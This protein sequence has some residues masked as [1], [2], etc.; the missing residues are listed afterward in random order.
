MNIRPNIR[1]A[2]LVAALAAVT[3]TAW[4][5]T[6][7]TDASWMPAG[8][9]AAERPIA[10]MPVSDS[11]SQNE[12][13]VS[14]SSDSGVSPLNDDARIVPVPF[15]AQQSSSIIVE[16]RRPSEDERIQM[17]VI[18]KL[19]ASPNLSGKIGV[20]TNGSVVTLTG[21]TTTAG[22]AWRAGR[23]AGSVA[24]VK[25]VQNEI[26]ARIGGSV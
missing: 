14:P 19:A 18:D 17:T 16:E 10:L 22:Q 24:G 20:V 4:A 11:L 12:T 21:Y 23:A 13:I 25:Y 9:P 1:N 26:R 6:E 8:T 7:M 2:T 3:M 5:T 15:V